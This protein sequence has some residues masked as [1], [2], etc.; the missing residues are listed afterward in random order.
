M[1]LT[2]FS[3]KI[4]AII[5]MTIDHVGHIFFPELIVLRVIG[6]IAFPI[7]A[8]FVALGYVH[9]RNKNKYMLRILLF[10]LISQVPY[11]LAFEGVFKLNV[12]FT[13]FI[14]LSIIK[15]KE[16]VRLF[17]FSIYAFALLLLSVISDWGIFGVIYILSFYSFRKSLK[18]QIISF[19][20][21][22]L[23]RSIIISLDSSVVLVLVHSSVLLSIPF[24]LLYN[25]EKGKGLK[26]LFYVFYPLHL[27][28]LYLISI[29]VI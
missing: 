25:K 23:L 9:T 29:I 22:T 26:Y 18:K 4:I 21:I 7:F 12:L 5:A 15:L 16:T 19:V 1:K 11:L 14:A 6:R 10:A 28:I 24:L 27:I 8:F 17:E 13:F 20:I 2:G 3:L